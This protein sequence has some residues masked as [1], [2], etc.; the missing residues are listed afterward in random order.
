MVVH[1]SEFYYLMLV[2]IFFDDDFYLSIKFLKI[3]SLSFEEMLDLPD[4]GGICV[5]FAFF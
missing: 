5:L 3:I 2:E 4:E 1:V